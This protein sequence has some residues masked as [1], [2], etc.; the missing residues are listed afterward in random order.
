MNGLDF[1][2]ISKVDVWV[3][4]SALKVTR[5]YPYFPTDLW[6]N[7][8]KIFKKKFHHWNRGAI[9]CPNPKFHL[10]PSNGLDFTAISKVGVGGRICHPG[11]RICHLLQL[12]DAGGYTSS[13][14]TKITITQSILKLELGNVSWKLILTSTTSTTTTGGR[15]CTPGDNILSPSTAFGCRRL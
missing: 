3:A 14:I 10:P 12:L 11:D 7:G 13:N 5:F 4:G 2:A 6:K 1:T 15:I 9:L 8:I